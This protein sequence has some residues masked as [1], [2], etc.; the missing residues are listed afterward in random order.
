MVSVATLGNNPS[1]DPSPPAA[2]TDLHVVST[3]ITD[4]TLMVRWK[5]TGN[6]G[7]IGTATGY[8]L[9]YSKLEIVDSGEV[10]PRTIDFSNATQAINLPS[11]K[12]AGSVETVTITGLTP[13]TPYFVALKVFDQGFDQSSSSPK[14]IS[15]L[16]NVVSTRT[17]MRNG[18]NMVSVPLVP[19]PNEVDSV[20][21]DDVGIPV[22]IS[23][24]LST[25]LD[26]SDGSY[27]TP[28][29]VQEG[30]GYII[31]SQGNLSVVDAPSGSQSL[32]TMTSTISLQR[33]WNIIGNPYDKRIELQEISVRKVET[34]ETLSFSNAVANG[35]VG[36]SLYLYNGSTFDAV[37]F[38]D[39]PPAALDLWKGY[40]FQVLR[41]DFTY[42][43]V[44]TKP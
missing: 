40:W 3:G 39:T 15:G 14:G 37:K 44:I 42:E 17:A 23:S 4:T 13:N 19:T 29:T 18:F 36:S 12:K 34:G 43:L 33:G 32:S 7:S 35:W 24:W 21:G 28:T 27:Q 38:D 10:A 5:A 6:D 11:P 2:I 8:D 31:Y 22:N 9:R 1:I 26:S 16:S 20:F 25:G 30:L 41:D